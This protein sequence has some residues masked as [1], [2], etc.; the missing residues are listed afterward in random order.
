MTTHIK[1]YGDK[2]D[3]F[4]AIKADL[5]CRLGYEPTNSEVLGLLMA[6]FDE[7]IGL[8]RPT[9]LTPARRQGAD[10]RRRE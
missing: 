1:L 5:T 9:N 7:A 2:A 3:R 8:E 6:S 4:E 10:T